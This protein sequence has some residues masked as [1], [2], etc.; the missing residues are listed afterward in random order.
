MKSFVG[1]F[2]SR[3]RAEIRNAT[4]PCAGADRTPWTEAIKNRVLKPMGC[5]R[6]HDSYEWDKLLDWVWWS[7]KKG[8]EL[9]LAVESELG[10]LAEVEQDFQK[11][12]SFKCP[13]KLLVF[14]TDPDKTKAMAEDYLQTFTQNVAAEQYVLVG[15][16]ER[17]TRCFFY[18]VPANG[19]PL[20]KVTFKELVI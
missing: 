18:S 8:E 10:T 15:F 5:V 17:G 9:V 16:T 6:G 12:P 1:E 13:R 19:K 11:L 20:V 14:S 4:P 2:V 3:V 7:K